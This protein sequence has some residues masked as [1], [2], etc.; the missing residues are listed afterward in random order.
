MR[1]DRSEQPAS[2][3]CRATIQ[4]KAYG[5]YIFSL[6]SK[7]RLAHIFHGIFRTRDMED[8][9]CKRGQKSA[10]LNTFRAF[11]GL[12]LGKIAI[13]W[14]TNSRFRWSLKSTVGSSE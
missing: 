2:P 3:S 11:W 10:H 4:K 6:S 12:R 9:V 7:P 5:S 1:E 8:F 13:G 14:K